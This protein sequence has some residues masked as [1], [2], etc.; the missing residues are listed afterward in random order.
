MSITEAINI[1]DVFPL[2]QAILHCIWISETSDNRY[3]A[4]GAS[5]SIEY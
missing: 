3:K 1:L 2:N 5:R 4:E